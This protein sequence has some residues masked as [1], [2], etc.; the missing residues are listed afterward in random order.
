MALS[1]GRTSIIIAVAITLSL[2]VS[3]S[4]VQSHS[5]T[6]SPY[7]V[8]SPSTQQQHHYAYYKHLQ[9]PIVYDHANAHTHTQQRVHDTNMNVHTPLS[10]ITKPQ[11]ADCMDGMPMPQCPDPSACGF[12]PA[13]NGCEQAKITPDCPNPEACESSDDSHHNSASTCPMYTSFT[14][15]YNTCLLFSTLHLQKPIH[16]LYGTAFIFTLC[17]LRELCSIHRSYRI[18]K[19]RSGGGVDNITSLKRTRSDTTNTTQPSTST[20]SSIYHAVDGNKSSSASSTTS[21]SSGSVNNRNTA[22]TT[23]NNDVRLSAPLLSS[24]DNSNSAASHQQRDR[25]TQWPLTLTIDSMLYGAA[26]TLSYLVMLLFMTY[27]VGVCIIVVVSC[28]LSHGVLRYLF[29][30]KYRPLGSKSNGES[31]D[32]AA[33]SAPIVNADHCCDDI[34]YD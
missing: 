23:A 31:N 13:C 3:L 9:Q 10:S 8:S 2:I 34:E 29:A 27:N 25:P 20:S 14:L 1:A 21:S 19:Q 18:R 26:L 11:C 17:F 33:A 12:K 5:S 4:P 16:W 30:K 7:D 28:T 22:S 6:R 24:N 32:A 15:S